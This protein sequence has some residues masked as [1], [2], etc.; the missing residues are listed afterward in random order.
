MPVKG[1][2]TALHPGRKSVSATQV[3][4]LR[5]EIDGFELPRPIARIERLLSTAP[6]DLRELGEAVTDES[7]LVFETLKLCNSS[8]FGLARPVS[9]LEQAVIVMDSDVV[10]TLIFACWLIKHT[11]SHVPERER[12]LFWQHS[13]LVAQLSRRIGEW[14]A[15]PSTE[16]GFLAGLFHDVGVLPFLTLYSQ[17]SELKP[18]T[19]L[20]REGDGVEPQRRRFGTDHCE[21]GLLLGSRLG[22][23][24]PLVEVAARH[25][26]RGPAALGTPLVCLV[27]AAEMISH[28]GAALGSQDHVTAGQFIRSALAEYLPGVNRVGGSGLVEALESDLQAPAVSLDA[29]PAGV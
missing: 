28:T 20:E 26:Q 27:A 9:S 11:A 29:M 23:P 22:F 25:H 5:A 2:Q 13:L 1:E 10:R 14:V 4:P 7:V 6:V 17:E 15:Y 16:W 18:D 8:L 3:N 21:L 12:R 24:V 19:L